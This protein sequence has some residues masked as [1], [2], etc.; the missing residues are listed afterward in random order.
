MNK[1]S[2]YTSDEIEE[3]LSTYLIDSWSYSRVSLFARNEKAFEM[4]AV[5][6]EKSKR[7][8]ASVQHHSRA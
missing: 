2:K 4:E 1:Y 7:S 3:L 6:R 5:Y 8:V